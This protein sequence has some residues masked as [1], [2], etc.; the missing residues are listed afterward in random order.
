MSG[1]RWGPRDRESVGSA[2]ET[3]GGERGEGRGERGE[4]V[5]P[6]VKCHVS[7]RR[8]SCKRHIN[9]LYNNVHV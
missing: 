7:K 5:V 2:G 6:L 4:G 9:K 1:R 3:P 8:N